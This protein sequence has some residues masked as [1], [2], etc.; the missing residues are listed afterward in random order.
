MK[1]WW[2][3]KAGNDGDRDG[4][5]SDSNSAYENGGNTCIDQ[6]RELEVSI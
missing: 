2:F 4:A 3:W 6:V 1:I 5:D